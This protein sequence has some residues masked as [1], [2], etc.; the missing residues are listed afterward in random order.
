MKEN[1]GGSL[2]FFAL[3]VKSDLRAKLPPLLY[4]C[5]GWLGCAVSESGVY[6]FFERESAF[7]PDK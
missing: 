6:P 3:V 4:K 2:I 7:H 1:E 5:G